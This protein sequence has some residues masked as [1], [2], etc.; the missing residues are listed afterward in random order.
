MTETND[1]QVDRNCMGSFGATVGETPLKTNGEDVSFKSTWAFDLNA[2]L[3]LFTVNDHTYVGLGEVDLNRSRMFIKQTVPLTVNF[4]H[5]HSNWFPLSHPPNLYDGVILTVYDSSDNYA[6]FTVK[7]G[8]NNDVE[9]SQLNVPMRTRAVGC[10]DGILY[11]LVYNDTARQINHRQQID[12]VKYSISSG[13]HV[14]EPTV[15]WEIVDDAIL[16]NLATTENRFCYVGRRVFV[17]DLWNDKYRIISLDLDT[18]KW[19]RT[20]FEFPRL[21]ISMHIEQ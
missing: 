20:S 7:M 14:Q 1:S 13:T 21:S 5:N 15:N 11:G 2:I 10:L 19:L 12:L 17:A 16:M 4:R 6:F 18:K 3:L 8:T 9:V